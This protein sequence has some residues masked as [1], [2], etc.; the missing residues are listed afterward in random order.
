MYYFC[1]YY[2][3]IIDANLFRFMSGNFNFYDVN[4]TATTILDVFK[5]KHN[6]YNSESYYIN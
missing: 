4:K 6:Y 1:L 5:I 2:C 3:H